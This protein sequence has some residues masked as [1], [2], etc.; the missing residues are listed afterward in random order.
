M[1]WKAI[2]KFYQTNQEVR[3]NDI[4]SL[5]NLINEIFINK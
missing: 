1:L 4:P 5:D 3:L 2:N